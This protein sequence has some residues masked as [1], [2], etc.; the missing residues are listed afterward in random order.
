MTKLSK[1]RTLR[2]EIG[3]LISGERLKPGD[4]LAPEHQ[5]AELF[6]VSRVTVRRALGELCDEGLLQRRKGKGTY[7][8]ERPV[9]GKA[10]GLLLG[11]FSDP[12]FGKIAEGVEEAAFAH[13]YQV[14]FSFTQGRRIPDII[15]RLFETSPVTMDG[16]IMAP[17]DSA[18]D[19]D[20]SGLLAKH[21]IVFVNAAPSMEGIFPVVMS[22]DFGGAYNMTKYLLSLGHRR[23]GHVRGPTNVSDAVSRRQGYT[24]AMREAGLFDERLVDGGVTYDPEDGFAAAGRLLA[25]P[26][27]PTAIFCASDGL[28]SGVYAF[29]NKQGLRIPAELSVAGYG[30]NRE[31]FPTLTTVDQNPRLIGAAAFERLLAVLANGG[32]VTGQETLLRTELL[33]KGSCAPSFAPRTTN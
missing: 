27:V 28:A 6:G 23:V 5:L 33:V 14:F 1:T 26:D 13:C 20:L 11:S 25:A 15:D 19:V 4:P 22:D 10:I 16:I 18:P 2:E 24:A 29:A 30:N 3:K 7:V 8:C 17:P 12:Y 9:S 32:A 31:L 21:D